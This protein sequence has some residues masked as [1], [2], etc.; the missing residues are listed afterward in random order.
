MEM[1]LTKISAKDVENNPDNFNSYFHTADEAPGLPIPTEKPQ[2][3]S[4]WLPLIISSLQ[5]PADLIQTLNLTPVQ[6]RLL[7]AA[8][9]IDD[10]IRPAFASLTF[11]PQGLFLRLDASSPKDGVKGTQ[12]LRTIDEIILRLATSHRAVN[13]ITALLRNGAKEIPLFFLLYNPKM[14]TDKEFR[15]FCPPGGGRISTVSQYRWHAPSIF[16]SMLSGELESKLKRILN[17]IGCVHAEIMAVV[18]ERRDEL[19]ELMLRQGFTFDLIELNSF[20]T[21]SGCG[22]CLF[23]W[24]R[25]GDVLYEK[26]EQRTGEAE[27]RVS[28]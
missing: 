24:L 7:H 13:A 6:G 21:R 19:D 25:D 15:V 20:G 23:H 4:R 2:H 9:N 17:E 12:P 18:E 3:Y 22:A 1:K 28:V 26:M 27:F 16:A 8:A 5:I 11:P 10:A 14:R